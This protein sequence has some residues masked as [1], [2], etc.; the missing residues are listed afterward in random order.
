MAWNKKYQGGDKKTA[1][2]TCAPCG[3]A[4]IQSWAFIHRLS[5]PRWQNC[6]HCSGPFPRVPGQAKGKVKPRAAPAGGEEDEGEAEPTEE[7]DADEVDEFDQANFITTAVYNTYFVSQPQKSAARATKEKS[8]AS[9]KEEAHTLILADKFDEAQEM[10]R[11][12]KE[13]QRVFM[14]VQDDAPAEPQLIDHKGLKQLSAEF[15]KLVTVGEAKVKK[16]VKF[17]LMVERLKNEYNAVKT[18]EA[19]VLKRIDS[20]HE[21]KVKQ[22]RQQKDLEMPLEAAKYPAQYIQKLADLKAKKEQMEMDLAKLPEEYA[23]LHSQAEA[24]MREE[25]KDGAPAKKPRTNDDEAAQGEVEFVEQIPGASQAG[26]AA[27]S[28]GAAACA[29]VITIAAEGDGDKEKHVKEQQHKKEA[30]RLAAARVD[31]LSSSQRKKKDKTKAAGG[32]KH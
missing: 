15:D 3:K 30:E 14:D 11:A 19:M 21:L 4:G 5:D 27:A 28:S 12:I 2:V 22:E 26:S 24:A 9:R 7:E 25:H 20:N 10:L 31:K 23:Q 13:E 17:E 18:A 1:Y 6:T 29:K 32:R 8:W 16:L